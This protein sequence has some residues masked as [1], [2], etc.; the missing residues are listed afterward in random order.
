M[1]RGH[2][3]TWPFICPI[4][5]DSQGL[6]FPCVGPMHRGVKQTGCQVASDETL[7]CPELSWSRCCPRTSHQGCSGGLGTSGQAV[8]PEVPSLL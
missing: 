3:H 4:S 2:L 5:M 1:T 7:L 6:W 8:S